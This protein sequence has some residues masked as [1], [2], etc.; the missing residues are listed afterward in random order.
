MT[1][2]CGFRGSIAGESVSTEPVVLDH[3]A[4]VL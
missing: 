4:V 3:S 2:G 1:D